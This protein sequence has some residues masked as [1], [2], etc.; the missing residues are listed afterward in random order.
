[1]PSVGSIQHYFR[2]IDCLAIEKR[3]PPLDRQTREKII[4]FSDYDVDC[5]DML[6]S[7]DVYWHRCFS[8]IYSLDYKHHMCYK[9]HAQCQ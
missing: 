4:E 6:Y 5:I 3:Q 1:M 7:I 8:N 2:A 9:S